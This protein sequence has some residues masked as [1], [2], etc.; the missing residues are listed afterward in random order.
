MR[1]LRAARAYGGA[2]TLLAATAAALVAAVVVGVA[3]TGPDGRPA[4]VVPL[5]L[6]AL[7]VVPVPTV[8]LAR[9]RRAEVALVR[10]RG[11]GPGRLLGAVAGPAVGAVLVGAAAG[12]AGGLAGASLLREPWDLP[13]APGSS[14]WVWGGVAA[15]VALLTA[16]A[17]CAAVAREPLATALVRPG[18]R[19]APGVADVVVGVALL[20]A[21]AVVVQRSR[22]GAPGDGGA[23][24][25]GDLVLAGS[26]VLGVAAG[27]A[28]VT[29]LR[30]LV[31]AVAADGRSTAVLLALRRVVAGDQRARTRAV[32]AAGVVAVAA[33]TAATA[34]G[35]WADRAARLDQGGPVRVALADTDALSAL[36]L[37]RD[38]DPE[39]RWLM[40]AAFD[41]SR[42]EPELRIAWLDLARY[43]RVS[44]DFLAGSAADVGPE[45]DSLRA[46]PAVAPVTGDAVTVTRA[47]ADRPVTVTLSFLTDDAGLDTA[48]VALGAG[49]ATGTAEVSTCPRACV[50]VGLTATAPVEVTA[51]GLGATDLLAAAWT[52]AGTTAGSTTGTSRRTTD[53][54][55]GGSLALGPAAPL[56]PS[57]ATTAIPVL[58][59]GRPSWP[60]AG[61]AVPGIGGGSRPAT[62]AGDRTALPLVGAA[63]VLAD[64][65]T[66]LAGAVD[67]VSGV[68]VLVLARADTPADVLAGLRDAGG[69]PVTF[70]GGEAALEGPW[71]AERHARSVVAVGAGALGL[72]VFL[73]GRRR[74]GLAARREHAALRL[75]GV[76]GPERRRADVLEAAVLAGATLAAT[77]GA[78]YL[79]AVTVVAATPLVPAG[80]ARPPIGS[81]VEP[82]V[83]L[84]GAVGTAVAAVLGAALVRA[85]AARRSDPARLLEE[86]S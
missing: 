32:V 13:A 62:A 29:G 69:D 8:E 4:T 57:A 72:L 25:G 52:S 45:T 66:A 19:R 41:A 85:G 17:G 12:A 81:T 74:R 75:V 39:G 86:E 73:A 77:A 55:T 37:T 56:A 83:L 11:A 38:L 70:G 27:H 42:D 47:G 16:L 59:A 79:A 51:L 80:P 1:V 22:G 60:D 3:A 53:Q 28:L 76:P 18:W 10:V 21:V 7:V 15:T 34:A 43:D 63:G 6:L 30:A 24:T 84:L 65:P 2:L 14:P 82:W 71:A 9:R 68:Q 78:G 46:A 58:T 33:L 48:S 35:G 40:A 61:P 67:S 23:P 44:G 64:L 50:V 5:L 26:A 49:E 36:L 20:V 31:P 54:T